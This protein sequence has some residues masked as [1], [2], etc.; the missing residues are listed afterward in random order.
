MA[1]IKEIAELTGLSIATVSHVINGTRKVSDKSRNLVMEAIKETG[2]KPNYA[3][4]MLRTRKSDTVAML[5]PNVRQ[6]MPT[7][8]FFMDVLSGAKDYLQSVGFNLIIDTYSEDDE[9]DEGD[10]RNLKVLRDQ[11]IDGFLVVP[12]KKKTAIVKNIMDNNNP[13]VLLD[14]AIKELEC[15]CVYNDTIK[16]SREVIEVFYGEG[17]RRIGYIGG[18]LS[19]FTGYDRWTGYK[20]GLEE[21]GLEYDERLISVSELHTVKNGYNSTEKLMEENV[22]A[23]YVS[24]DVQAIGVLKCL[25]E[26]NI[27]IGEEIAVI[28][29][30]NY[31]W[32]EI[33]SPGLTTVS[34]KPYEMGKIGAQILHK[35]LENEK[36]DK[37]VILNPEI[38]FRESHKSK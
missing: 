38:I 27:K 5:I 1:S 29:F 37:K 28:G 18:S 9:N 22:D 15:P 30:E 3:A 4:R 16:I 12:N 17:K 31:E 20:Q 34:Q 35:I 36:Y 19:S 25:K 21:C 26:K 32:M 14:R 33:C 8:I 7:N 11:W 10:L 24:N 6:G 13:C 2:Y 23:I